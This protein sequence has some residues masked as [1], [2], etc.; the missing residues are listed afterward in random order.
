VDLNFD[1]SKRNLMPGTLVIQSHRDPLPHP[2]LQLC[3]DSVKAWARTNGYDY[4]FV[5]DELFDAVDTRLQKNFSRQK[6][7][8]SDLARLKWLQRALGESYACVVWCDADFLIFEQKR[9]LLPE[10]AYALGRELW[11]QRDKAGKLR[12]YRKVHNAL[13][14]FRQG[15]HF[16]DFY[17]DSAE[18]LLGLN[19]GG[20]PAQFIGPKLLTALHNIV[21][22]PVMECAGMLSPL[23]M[24]DLLAG[25]GDALDL[26]RDKSQE[27]IAGA[28]LSS[29]LTE[30]E[31]SSDT[32]METL[33]ATL[34][35]AGI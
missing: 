3:L 7:V 17:A 14:M 16:L 32:D 29:S 34:L 33:I 9:F 8:V 12:V 10:T 35:E 4:R 22:C 5:G 18:Q 24:R 2:W 1:K 15:N 21:M 13:L 23:V 19:Q 6:I 30:T 20:V 27:S 11:V 31:G 25:K 26:F 28:N